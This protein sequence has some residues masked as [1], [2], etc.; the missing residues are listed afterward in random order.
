MDDVVDLEA[1]VAVLCD[2]FA[3][4]VQHLL[5]PSDAHPLLRD[6]LDLGHRDL[7]GHFDFVGFLG[8]RA[9][10]DGDGTGAIVVVVVLRLTGKVQSDFVGCY[11]FLGICFGFGM[12]SGLV[13]LLISSHR[14]Y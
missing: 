11:G 7:G 4:E 6:L 9:Q 14:L 1:N 5:V 13:L 2:I 8:G 10:V 3:V 12:G